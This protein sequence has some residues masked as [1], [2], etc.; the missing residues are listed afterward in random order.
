MN[1]VLAH[2]GGGTL[3]PLQLLAVSV[4]AY[5]YWRRS[6]RL[7][8]EHRPIPPWRVACF[9]AGIVLITA[10]VVSPLAHMGG[11]LLL[12]HMAQHLLIGDIAALLIVLGLTGP[13]LQPLLA[14]KAIDRLRV[15]THPLIA[16]PLWAASLYIWH[17][18]ALY[19]A[20]LSSEPVHALQHA[21]FI[22]FG[23]L[24]W[25]PLLGPLPQPRWF[26]IGAKLGYVVSVRF[27]GTVLGNV[28]MWSNTVFYPDYAPGE[29]DFGISPLSD[30]GTA[31]VIMTVEGGACDARGVLL[32]LPALGAAGHR[33]PAPGR[34]GRGAWGGADARAR[35]ARG[36]RGP[37]RAARGEDQG[38]DLMRGDRFLYVLVFVVGMGSLGA[39]IS[40]A[41]LMAPFFGASTIVWANIIGVVLVALSVGYWFG[42]R[43]ADRHPHLR[44]L[45]LMVM[46]AAVLLAIVPF[47][48]D[49]FFEGAVD[50]LD[51]ISAGAFVGS[52]IAVL[53]LIAVPVML[54]G[55]CAPWAVRLATPDVEHAGRTTGRLYAISTAGSLAGTMLSS[56]V[57]IPF[58]G[59][60]RTFIVFALALGL[61]AAA[62]LGWR[63]LAAP[64]ALAG[65]IAIPVGTVNAT[66]EAGDRVI[67]DEE[68]EYQYVRVI[69]E[70]DG[71][72]RLELN[73]GIAQHS[74]YSP[75]TYITNG[76]WDGLLVLPFLN[77][78]TPPERVAVLGNAAGTSARGYGHY[79]PQT[80]IDG[81][82]ID[83][84]L[85]EVG[86]R[87]FDMT[88]PNLTRPQ[89]G[90]PAVAA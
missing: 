11:E 58:L 38:L 10:G 22:G 86:R 90:R 16:L 27:V 80:K 49:P 37:G 70:R 44:G 6:R 88:N 39:E 47:A 63:Y 79:F 28:F 78:A 24:M 2:V 35:R 7:A 67:Y 62:G 64:V 17:I 32:A 87:F 9:A 8:S 14:I 29:A 77:R 15:L 53:V 5:A 36:A 46:A 89:R 51:E 34:A 42:G 55:A 65:A 43:L 1:P 81:V 33:A 48:A 23:I 75:R 72:R 85:E 13:L 57:L 12:A 74:F 82:E 61:V 50:A 19:Q 59:T 30:Q 73:E 54:M 84:E 71:D 4:V 31:G 68:T 69:E 3:E 20:S 52:L 45:C 18:P 66:T 76:Y 21:C 25:M 83:P 41:R 60:Q 56:L 26:G 40:V